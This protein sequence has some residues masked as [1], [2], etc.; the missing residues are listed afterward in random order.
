MRANKR[1]RERGEG[2]RQ[3]KGESGTE[4]ERIKKRE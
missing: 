1:E 4:S 2:D 3:R